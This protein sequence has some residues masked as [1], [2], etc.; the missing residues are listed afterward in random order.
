MIDEAFWE[1]VDTINGPTAP[2][3]TRCWVWVGATDKHGY[4]SLGR[5]VPGVPG[6]SRGQPGNSAQLA[7][8]YGVSETTIF[9]AATGRTYKQEGK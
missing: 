9:N 4:G 8:T 3:L 5:R 7:R 6:K 1:K 2:G